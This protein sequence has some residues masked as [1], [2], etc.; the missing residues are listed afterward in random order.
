M[1]PDTRVGLRIPVKEECQSQW[2]GSAGRQSHQARL[3]ICARRP[4]PIQVLALGYPG[5]SGASYFDYN[6]TDPI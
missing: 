1:G 6:V 5:T 2:M 4:A 3:G